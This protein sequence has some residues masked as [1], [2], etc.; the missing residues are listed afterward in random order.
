M[1]GEPVIFFANP[2]P[3]FECERK[4]ELLDSKLCCLYAYFYIDLGPPRLIVAHYGS[5]CLIAS[6]KIGKENKIR[7]R[8]RQIEIERGGRGY[9]L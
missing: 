6:M 9:K 1:K 5:V 3:K 7:I 2:N 8:K 4:R